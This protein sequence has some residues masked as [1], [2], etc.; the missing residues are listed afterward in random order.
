MRRHYNTSSGRPKKA[1]FCFT[2]R[3]MLRPPKDVTR[4]VFKTSSISAFNEQSASYL[5]I[6]DYVI[7][8]NFNYFHAEIYIKATSTQQF[9]GS[10]RRYSI[11]KDVRKKFTGKHLCQSLFINKET[12][13]QVFS[14]KFS[15]IFKNTFLQNTSRQ[16]PYLSIVRK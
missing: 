5:S 13:P 15:K 11:K 2:C 14:C 12:L 1:G 4:E 9:S 3:T 16:L 6:V 8:F 7:L 10:H